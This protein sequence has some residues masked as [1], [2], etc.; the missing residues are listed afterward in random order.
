ME[1]AFLSVHGMHIGL[2]LQLMYAGEISLAQSKFFSLGPA[3]VGLIVD[4]GYKR[5]SVS[6]LDIC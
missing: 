3:M 6:S 4:P 5:M 1:F 2:Y